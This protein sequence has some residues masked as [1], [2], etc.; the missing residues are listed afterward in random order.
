MKFRKEAPWYAFR[1]KVN[2]LFGD[3]PDIRV[4]EIYESDDGFTDFAFDVEVR[5][6]EK[7]LALD[8]VMPKVKTYGNVR[9]GIVLFDEENSE[10]EGDDAVVLFRTIFADNPI[11][12]DIKVAA[13]HTGTVHGYVRFQPEVIQYFD[14]DISDYNGNWSGLAMDIARE[15]F[16][17]SSRGVHFCTAEVRENSSDE[18]MDEE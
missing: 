18:E 12:K 8:R 2:A 10:N 11:L 16:A 7:F 6:H 13:D 14:D 5:N 15:I 4:G 9:L 3:D 1:K 17:D